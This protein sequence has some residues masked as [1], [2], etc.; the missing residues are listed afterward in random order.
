[1]QQHQ[2]VN[3]RQISQNRAEQVGYYRFLENPQVTECELIRS[4]SDHCERQVCG[5]HV[6][7]ISDTSE[8]NLHTHSGR[9]KP[10]GLGVVGNNRDVGFF[11]HP[12]LVLNAATGF[13]LGLSDVHLWSR[14]KGH[15]NKH[16]RNYSTLPIEDK[17]SYK[18]LRSGERS[19]RCLRAG[20]AKMITH[21]GDR[22]SDIYEEW[23]TVPERYTHLLIRVC[24]D[25]RLFNQSASLYERLSA[26]PCEGTYWLR[27]ES[28]P[29]RQQ[30][31]REAFLVV[32]RTPVE[33]QRPDKVS[34]QHY[35]DRIRLYAVEARE[36][37]PPVGQKPIHWRDYSQPMR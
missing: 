11:I 17:E 35:P 27:V 30:T 15:A 6:L 13:P 33:I 10:K 3:I 21:I 22:E 29:R 32:R 28:D 20:D 34:A 16:E 25:R 4:L 8:I 5:L 18:W 37:N 2:S 26:Q 36:V 14:K 19:N 31:A 7:A 24:R 12:S 1:M 23:A 9:L